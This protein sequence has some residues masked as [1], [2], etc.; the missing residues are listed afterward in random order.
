[1]STYLVLQPYLLD[2]TRR[3]IPFHMEQQKKRH[4]DLLHPN[5]QQE[6]LTD[7]FLLVFRSKSW[8]DKFYLV[9]FTI[10]DL[11]LKIVIYS[12]H[13]S[14][15]SKSRTEYFSPFHPPKAEKDL[16][17][18][19]FSIRPLIFLSV[20]T[21]KPSF[22]QKCSKFEFV[23]RFPVQLWAISW[24]IT[25]AKLRSPAWKWKWRKFIQMK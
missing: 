16:L 14:A 4:Q 13:C 12:R 6:Q 21:V 2:T 5:L 25:P 19:P 8:Y 20:K 1:M 22:N 11:F 7:W 17:A 15:T 18:S 24:A 23:T 10:G 9:Y 3:W